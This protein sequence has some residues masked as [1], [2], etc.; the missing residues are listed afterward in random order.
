MAQKRVNAEVQRTKLQYAE[1]QTRL[2]KQKAI[3][4]ALRD[5]EEAEVDADLALLKQQTDTAVAEAEVKV[6]EEAESDKRSLSLQ[7]DKDPLEKVKMTLTEKYVNEQ[8]KEVEQLKSQDKNNNVPQ[9]IPNNQDNFSSHTP[10]P[11]N[12]FNI[13]PTPRNLPKFEVDNLDRSIAEDI[14]P[15]IRQKQTLNPCAADFEFTQSPL[16][17]KHDQY[18]ND[19]LFI[20]TKDDDKIGT[21]VEDRLFLNL[22]DSEFKKDSNGHWTAPSF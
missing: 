11:R 4:K 6:L 12:Q 16:P 20:K 22:M 9:V 5:R 13:N 19:P 10:A 17:P 18:N 1:Q 14:K 8:F 7:D 15:E 21:S 2:I 3:S